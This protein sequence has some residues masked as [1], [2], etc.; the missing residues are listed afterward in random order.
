[1][2]IAVLFSGR[3]FGFSE[4]IEEYKKFIF[5]DN[6]V[7][8]FIG[9]NSYNT[10]DLSILNKY[11]NIHIMSKLYEMPHDKPI[12]Y[13]H[14]RVDPRGYYL[15][16]MWYHRNIA[17]EMMKEYSIKNNVLFDVVISGR[18]D[19]IMT[20]MLTIGD[21]EENTLYIPHNFD[22]GGINDQFAYGTMS[23]MEVYCNLYKN[24]KMHPSGPEQLLKNYLQ[25]T[26]INIKRIKLNYYLC[27]NRH[28]Y[29][30]ERQ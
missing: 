26:G 15:S 27:D 10:E 16:S 13:S 17:Y 1:M 22:Y 14:K 19:S 6:P 18:T 2:H 29:N 11:N 30:K 9:H 5:K 12:V 20:S 21:L 24:V 4:S 25:K 28:I 7:I 23:S 8:I 3:I